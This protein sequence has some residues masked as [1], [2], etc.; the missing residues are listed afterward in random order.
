MLAGGVPGE[1]HERPREAETA[2]VAHLGGQAERTQM[3]DAA[4]GGETTQGIGE[5]R[6]AI[7]G[8]Q[9]GVDGGHRGPSSQPSLL[10]VGGLPCGLRGPEG[11]GQVGG[12]RNW[13]ALPT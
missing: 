4:V 7:P 13:H 11:L 1:G 9:I 3:G 2:P 10:R 12:E 6:P 5:R 8:G